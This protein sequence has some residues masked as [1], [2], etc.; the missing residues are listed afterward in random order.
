MA[1][2]KE[3]ESAPDHVGLVML[4]TSISTTTAE[5][6]R[7][8]RMTSVYVSQAKARTSCPDTEG[9]SRWLAQVWRFPVAASS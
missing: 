1:S 8:R 3:R 6:I 4:S 2:L 9:S 7:G 5:V